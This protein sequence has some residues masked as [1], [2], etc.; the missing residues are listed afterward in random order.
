MR[1]NIL[2]C[3]F[4]SPLLT[5]SPSIFSPFFYCGEHGK[6]DEMIFAFAIFA[7]DFLPFCHSRHQ[8]SHHFCHYGKNG[9]NC[10]KK[11][12]TVHFVLLYMHKQL[13]RVGT[14]PSNQRL[15]ITPID[16]SQDQ[17]K[18]CHGTTICAWT[19]V[20]G[21]TVIVSRNLLCLLI[22]CVPYC[23]PKHCGLHQMFPDLP[24]IAM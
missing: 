17:I 16:Q 9:E 7:I 10:E 2:I 14:Q 8:F 13:S 22:Y 12:F 18:F 1:H 20:V 19:A 4:F 5:F 6:K 11:S 21:T 3:D 23:Y 24:C 15:R